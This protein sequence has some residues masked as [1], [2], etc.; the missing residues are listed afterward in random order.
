LLNIRKQNQVLSMYP[1]LLFPINAI[2]R[3][4][5]LFMPP[6]RDLTTVLILSARP[7]C[8]SNRNY[9][10]LF[11]WFLKQQRKLLKGKKVT[12]EWEAGWRLH[13]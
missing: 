2:P 12:W 6:E 13:W 10:A 9:L 7:T 4:N 5:F 11:C 3:D 8:S 1:T